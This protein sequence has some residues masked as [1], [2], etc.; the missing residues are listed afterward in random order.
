MYVFVLAY[1]LSAARTPP[2]LEDDAM[3]PGRTESRVVAAA[4]VAHSPANPVT[5]ETLLAGALAGVI[6]ETLMH[7]FETVRA[8][9]V[10]MTLPYFYFG[11]TN[12]TSG[13]GRCRA[14][15][16]SVRLLHC[17]TLSAG[18]GSADALVQARRPPS[19]RCPVR[20]SLA[21]RRSPCAPRCTPSPR[22]APSRAPS[23]SSTRR[24]ASAA[25]SR[26]CAPR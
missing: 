15:M 9:C 5:T 14:N 2:I 21:S 13:I 7:P 18:L 8:R 6:S 22:S 17:S 24:R 1:F 11:T 10:G 23:A 3:E 16:T 4:N 20:H 25:I 12:L 26:A 19:R